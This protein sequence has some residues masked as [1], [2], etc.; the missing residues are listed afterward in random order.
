MGKVLI[1]KDADFSQNAIDG[2]KDYVLADSITFDGSHYINI[3]RGL[4]QQ[5]KVEICFTPTTAATG[6]QIIALAGVR[7]A[8]LYNM[9]DFRIIYDKGR[10]LL[11]VN[12][13]NDGQ[14]AGGAV[15][16]NISINSKHTLVADIK[17]N[18][19][20]FDDTVQPQNVHTV[21]GFNTG[22]NNLYIGA[23]NS[24]GSI[25]SAFTWFIGDIHW[26][27][28]YD[29]ETLSNY[30]HAATIKVDGTPC[31]VDRLNDANKYYFVS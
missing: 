19:V 10:N 17:N 29:N 20:V 1:F 26:I 30:F 9:L 6:S 21:T 24:G 31:L 23:Y 5:S 18:T 11:A 4:T 2:D 15:N 8:A 13:Q 12:M 14:A 27:K 3:G 7:T 16:I 22:S 28:I 25:P